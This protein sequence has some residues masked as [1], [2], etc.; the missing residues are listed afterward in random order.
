MI[1]N[2]VYSAENLIFFLFQEY[3]RKIVKIIKLSL[4]YAVRWALNASI[5]SFCWTLKPNK[6][7]WY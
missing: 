2:G 3:F 1:K 7:L 5:T 6:N 4:N